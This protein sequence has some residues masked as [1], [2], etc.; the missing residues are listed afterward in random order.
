MIKNFFKIAVR[1][2]RKHKGYSFLNIFGLAMGMTCSLL[3]LLWIRDEQSVDGFHAMGDRIYRVYERQYYDGKVEAGYYTPGVLAAEMKKVLPE[4]EMAS[5]FTWEDNST[6][7]VGDKI[8]KE[9]GSAAGGDYFQMFSYPLLQGSPASAL[10]GPSSIAISRKMAVDF[11]GSPREAIGKPIRYQ[12]NKN[13][14]VAAVFEDLP[15]NVSTKFDYLLNW[16]AFLED[17]SWAKEWGNNGPSTFLLLR[18]DAN[19]ALV[20]KKIARFLDNYNKEQG[21]GFHIELG[22]QRAADVY[23]HASFKD[24]AIAGGRIEYVRLF[25]IVAIFI[26]L[27]ACIN[28][29]NLTTARSVNRAKEIGIRKVVG[30]VRPALIRQFISEAV[31]LSFFSM[32]FALAMV[33]LLL[34]AFNQL[35]GKHIHFPYGSTSFWLWMAALTLMTGA[36]AGS[37]PALVLS[38]FQ[39]I[40]VLK[41]SLKFTA[42][43]ALFRKGLVVFQF[44]L[45]IVLIIGT[46]V[47]AGQ[48]NYVRTINL[49]F[50]REDLLYI[51]LEGDLTA[52]Y[53]LFK[54]Q[55]ARLPGVSDVTRISQVPTSIENSTFGV[56][57]DGK[58]PNTKP[59]FTQVSVGY[60]LARTLHLQLAAGRDF[61]KD[62][63]T[64]S[65]GYILNEAAL[66]KVG[67]KDPIGRRLT[68]WDKKGQI[69][70]VLRDFHF[71]SLHSPILPLIIRL[72]EEEGWGEAMVRTKAG[73]A[74]QALAG[75]ERLCKQ[76]NPKFPFSYRFADEEYQKLYKSESIVQRLSNCFASLAICISCLGLLGL[77]MFT[78]EQRTKEFGIRKVL[79]AK[80]GTLFGLLSR[81][82][83][84][85]VLVAFLLASPLAWWAMHTW[86]QN[87]AYHIAVQWWVFLLAGG[88][89]L[90]IALLT[91]S[92]Q[93]MKVA[94]ANPVKSLRAE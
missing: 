19:P 15:E 16:D 35:T 42:G 61:S 14:T 94:V 85:L 38:S 22:M 81:E 59:M 10:A 5:G 29:M 71:N 93:A 74:K 1:N 75:L 7:Q 2:L 31:L 82:F 58:D 63:P 20:T 64:D 9:K 89:A 47:V 90:L 17:N 76:L 11:F 40:R 57:W 46:I 60:D 39:P 21:K 45:S 28:F 77:A 34:P 79:G 92:F 83:L 37:Y 30:A 27:I 44:V 18:K 69:V 52:K 12:N 4:V 13:F 33:I 54:E 55:A 65:V 62:F 87:F 49:G 51:P 91:V 78:A 36:I 26:L 25:S 50:D 53:K 8:L 48:I 66:K 3:I 86:L 80:V 88:A 56:D 32:I 68:F 67:Y 70:G 23:L 72:R 73:Q 84:L 24:G 41:G 6:F 43:A